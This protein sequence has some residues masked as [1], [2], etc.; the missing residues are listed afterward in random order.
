MA[1]NLYHL[2][3][4]FWQTIGRRKFEKRTNFLFVNLKFWRYFLLTN[5][6]NSVPAVPIGAACERFYK[7]SNFYAFSRPKFEFLSQ[8][9]DIF[10]KICN[11][12]V[13]NQFYLVQIFT[14]FYWFLAK[15]IVNSKAWHFFLHRKNLFF[16]RSFFARVIEGCLRKG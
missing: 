11:F 10:R 9:L 12:N 13:Q 2:S 6:I 14:G 4:S 8:N 7:S 15:K 1:Q 5:K 3:E 16:H